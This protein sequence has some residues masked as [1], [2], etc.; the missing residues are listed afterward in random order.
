[1]QLQRGEIPSD[2][3]S[4]AFYRELLKLITEVE[5]LKAEFA[6]WKADEQQERRRT[7]RTK[8]KVGRQSKG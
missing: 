3:V 7:G 1:M 8:R 5:C 2:G 6:Y 4:V